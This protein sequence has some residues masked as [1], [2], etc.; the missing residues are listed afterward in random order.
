MN[1]KPEVPTPQAASGTPDG[2]IPQQAGIPIEVFTQRLAIPGPQ[3]GEEIRAALEQFESD[4]I[5]R[6]PKTKGWVYVRTRVFVDLKVLADKEKKDDNV[7]SGPADG[8]TDVAVPEHDGASRNDGDFPSD[9]TP[10]G[11]PNGA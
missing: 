1:D 8:G 5:I 6:D 7:S 4:A 2:T 10:N 9:P 3:N 11:D